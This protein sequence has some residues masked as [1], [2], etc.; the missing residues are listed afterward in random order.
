MPWY[1]VGVDGQTGACIIICAEIAKSASFDW[2]RLRV[3]ASNCLPHMALNTGTRCAGDKVWPLSGLHYQ[4]HGV[5]GKVVAT[6][7]Y[8]VGLY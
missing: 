3:H 4:L 8:T 7:M 2:P 1:T 5:T 6:C